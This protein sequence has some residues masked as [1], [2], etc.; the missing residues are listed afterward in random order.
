MYHK[1][2]HPS[3]QAQETPRHWVSW[4]NVS[5]VLF[6]ISSFLFLPAATESKNYICF[7][8][9]PYSILNHW[10]V[11]LWHVQRCVSNL[12]LMNYRILEKY[13]FSATLHPFGSPQKQ[14]W[15]NKQT[16]MLEWWVRTSSECWFVLWLFYLV[17][18]AQ[19]DAVWRKFRLHEVNQWSEFIRPDDGFISTSDSFNVHKV[20]TWSNWILFIYCYKHTSCNRLHTW[21]KLLQKI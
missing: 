13:A 14:T 2:Q 20:T 7:A 12:S 16:L 6:I 11:L 10:V 9:L 18:A 1:F 15:M 8:K 3:N 4:R 21:E 17:C 19:W 5:F